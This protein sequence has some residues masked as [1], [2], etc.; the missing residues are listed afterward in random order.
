KPHVAH[1]LDK[2]ELRDRVQALILAYEAGLTG[3]PLRPFGPPPHEWGGRL[4]IP[5]V[6]YKAYNSYMIPVREARDQLA[7]LVNRVAYRNERITLGRR[8]KKIAAIV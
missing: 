8:G 5:Y 4:R 3:Y 6:R 7:D 1:L 2:L